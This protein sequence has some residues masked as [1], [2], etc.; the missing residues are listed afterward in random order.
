MLDFDPAR[1]SELTGWFRDPDTGRRREGGDP[2][3]E[4][5]WF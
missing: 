2:E 5:V 3:K 1:D 4:T